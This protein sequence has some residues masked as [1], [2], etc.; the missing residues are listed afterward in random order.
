M[1][2][3]NNMDDDT[4]ALILQLQLED[5]QE[6]FTTCEGKGKG[7][8]GDISDTQLALNLYREDLE[9][10]VS[11]IN[12]RKMT[13]SLARA[14]Q[15]DGNALAASLCEE[16]TAASDFAEACRLGSIAAPRPLGSSTSKAEDIDDEFLTKLSSLYMGDFTDPPEPSSNP[17]IGHLNTD[18]QAAESSTWAS[19]RKKTSKNP[20]RQC[21]ACQD[22]FQIY[23]IARAPCGH[24]YCR[25][26]LQD[27]YRSSITDDSLFP[28]RCCHQPMTSPEV[29]IFLTRD[30]IRQYEQKK[31]ELETPNRTYCCNQRCS[32]F[33]R[34]ENIHSDH[35]TCP[36][37]GTRTC[38]MCKA[39]EHNGDCPAD[40]A[41]QQL[42]ETANEN[43][44]QRCYS[45]QRLVELNFGCNHITFAPPPTPSY[46]PS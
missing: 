28:P 40:G 25:A 8:E 16:Q 45:C 14:C 17:P 32:A 41:L 44:W 34:A 1:D 13:R 30:L 6:L 23:D 24:E 15:T 27:L 38:T 35:G 46:Y 37:C 12:D 2:V 31:I 9:R 4:A 22:M 42:L 19:S 3:S 7:R 10:N 29:K 5:S 21:T 26:C 43:G 20:D 36:N 18:S 33:L 11:I 39:P